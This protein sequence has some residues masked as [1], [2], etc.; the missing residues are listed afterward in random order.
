MNTGIRNALKCIVVF[1]LCS[2]IAAIADNHES[3]DCT[4]KPYEG[5]YFK[6]LYQSAEQTAMN[7]CQQLIRSRL[8]Q[9]AVDSRYI[10][11]ILDDFADGA[12]QHL[13]QLSLHKSADYDAQ[14]GQISADFRA[15]DFHDIKM[16]ELK[17]RRSINTGPQGYFEPLRKEVSRFDIKEVDQCKT[18]APDVSC[19]AVFKDYAS[20]FN[21]YRSAYDNIYDN[22]EL[23]TRLGASWDS[24]LQASKSQTALEVYLTTLA[25]RKH[26]QKDHLV[27]PPSYQVIALHPRLIYNSMDKAPDGS[28]QE[29]GLAVEWIGANFWDLKIGNTK[30]P[31]GASFTS[32]YVDRPQVRDV[33]HGLMLHIYN[34]YSIGWASHDSKD[35][36][37][38]S[39]DLLKM[40][41]DKK[42]KYDQY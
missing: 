23:L 21:P 33:G 37:Y 30:M 17:V 7:F 1:A 41:E 35:S 3:I 15:F 11:S 32:V 6:D 39:I 38:V 25:H 10:G 26:F 34:H 16:P 36:F 19:E 18:I 20:A 28:N 31:L 42:S 22:Q 29:I 27:G 9:N 40:F 12:K 4:V 13:D 14:F 8:G 5:K 2:P 24:F